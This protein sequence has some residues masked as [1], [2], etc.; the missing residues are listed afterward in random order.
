MAPAIPR[1]KNE[2]GDYVVTSFV[3]PDRADKIKA[4]VEKVSELI[5]PQFPF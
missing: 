4:A 1:S 2:R 5:Y 3:I